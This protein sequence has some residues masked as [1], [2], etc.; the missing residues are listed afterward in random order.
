MKN[1]KG[2]TL[3]ELIVAMS[4]AAI[5]MI[6]VVALISPSTKIFNRTEDSSDARLLAESLLEEIRHQANLSTELKAGD[7]DRAGNGSVL[8]DQNT[9]SI[10]EEGYIIETKGG[11]SKKLF[12][13]KFYKN[14]TIGMTAVDVKDTP[15]CVDMTLKIYSEGRELY[16]VDSRLKPVLDKGKTV[17]NGEEESGGSGESSDYMKWEDGNVYY[18]GDFVLYQGEL[19]V[20]LQPGPVT[21]TKEVQ[22]DWYSMGPPQLPALFVKLTNRILTEADKSPMGI[23]DL[24]NPGDQCKIGDD[25]YVYLGTGSAWAFLPPGDHWFKVNTK[26]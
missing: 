23:F 14:K 17:V 11:K 2:F 22:P 5:F 1:K 19:Y 18:R 15:N 4:V 26:N 8:I 6:C 9:I 12:D 7:I 21:I 16:S 10:D 25:L 20:A 3:I 24:V 13:D